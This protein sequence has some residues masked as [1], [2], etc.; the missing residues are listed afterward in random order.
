MYVHTGK[1]SRTMDD[2]ELM[3]AATFF[4]ELLAKPLRPWILHLPS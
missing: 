4:Q 2:D 1:I 3:Y